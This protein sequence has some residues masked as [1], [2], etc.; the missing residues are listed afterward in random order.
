MA[1]RGKIGKYHIFQEKGT[2]KTGARLLL[3]KSRPGQGE[4]QGL[5]KIPGRNV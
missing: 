3:K 2:V 4:D 5:E 1:S